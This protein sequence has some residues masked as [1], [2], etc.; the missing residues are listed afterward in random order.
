MKPQWTNERNEKLK[1]CS[2]K[3]KQKEVPIPRGE[4][5]ENEGA[6]GGGGGERKTGAYTRR[7]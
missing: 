7:S 2:E 4:G 6:G 3:T 5:G 1:R